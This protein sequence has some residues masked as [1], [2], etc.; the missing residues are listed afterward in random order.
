MSMH[1]TAKFLLGGALMLAHSPSAPQA[2]PINGGPSSLS[3][4]ARMATT[5]EQAAHRRCGWRD[6]VRV[7]RRS[8]HRP[9]A[10][11]DGPSYGFTYGNPRADALPAGSAEWWRAME[12]EGR[13][14]NSRR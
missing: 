8:A 4:E 2:A 10:S 13:T 12:R 3:R 11:W 7:C 14:G 6:G 5:V 9:Y 1:R